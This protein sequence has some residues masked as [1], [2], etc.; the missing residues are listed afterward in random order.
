MS[1]VVSNVS[2]TNLAGPVTQRHDFLKSLI[3]A[4]T[5]DRS[6]ESIGDAIRRGY[7]ASPTVQLN[8]LRRWA[9][10]QGNA[11][12]LGQ[13]YES[14]DK[15]PYIVNNA[16]GTWW[17]QLPGYEDIITH[18]YPIVVSADLE[19]HWLNDWWLPRS[20]ATWTNPATAK[21]SFRTKRATRG[22][23]TFYPFKGP[24]V[25]MYWAYPYVATHRP[26]GPEYASA[27]WTATYNAATDEIHIV[28]DG[29]TNWTFN[30]GIDPNAQYLYQLYSRGF[31]Y[32]YKIGTGDSILDEVAAAITT[33]PDG[34]YYPFIPVRM[35][36]SSVQNA[37]LELNTQAS[38]AFRKATGSKFSKLVAQIDQHPDVG[39]IDMSMVVPGI[40]ANS[41][42]R[43]ARRY[44]YAYCKDLWQRAGSP[45]GPLA[46][47]VGN[48]APYP[49]GWGSQAGCGITFKYIQEETGTGLK[50]AG[51]TVGSLWWE[52]VGEESRL[53]WQETAS[54]WRTLK[55][56]TAIGELTG[57]PGS[58]HRVGLHN[59]VGATEE[60]SFVFPLHSPT[61]KALGARVS[62]EVSGEALVMMVGSYT[63]VNTSSLL[64]GL[65]FFVMAVLVVAFPPGAAGVGLLGTN[66]AVGL[67]LGLSGSLA[68]VAGLIVNT[69][70]AIIVT[71]LIQKASVAI[72]G[73]KLGAIVGAVVGFVAVSVG[74]GLSNGMDMSAI[75]SSMG[76]AQNI[77]QLTS[78]VGSGISGYVQAAIQDLSQEMTAF[79][80]SMEERNAELQKLYAKNIGYG[81][82]SLNAMS[83]TDTQFGN[84]SETPEQFLTRTLLTGTDIAEITLGMLTNFAEL[85][86]TTELPNNA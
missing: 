34:G 44:I 57:L 59:V 2:A 85:T 22:L 18:A 61:L 67:A 40:Q 68:V 39:E 78:A 26:S 35:S 24:P 83:L 82:G 32:P 75:W 53:H 19:W 15:S 37:C 52:V 16:D 13:T 72:L 51:A 21:S 79:N 1:R 65:I 73:D 62:A 77:L 31:S 29:T 55:L 66:M 60:A 20:G 49:G 56:G 8:T 38:R 86:T 43:F 76:S 48:D 6:K 25:W 30:P 7:S 84:F 11:G 71:K 58:A 64:S 28:F 23:S 54:S 47:L 14:L 5:F 42:S 4:H 9:R 36:N 63:L 10:L 17:V 41:Q 27:P 46:V 70:A 45:A 50:V 81:S 69:L 12:F 74:T 33:K 80:Q 3:V